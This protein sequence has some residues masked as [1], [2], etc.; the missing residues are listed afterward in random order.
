M[1]VRVAEYASTPLENKS[2]EYPLKISLKILEK[3]VLTMLELWIFPITLHVCQAFEDTLNPKCAWVLKM[4]W[5]CI[6][7][8]HRVLNMSEYGS[9][10]LN[11]AWMS[12]YASVSLNMHEHG[13]IFL[14]IPQYAWKCLNKLFWLWQ[15]SQHTSSS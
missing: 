10:C 4:T 2:L 1:P 15:G 12:Q 13:W 14:N 11:N 6:Q 3:T 5:L 8:L 7:G 9:I